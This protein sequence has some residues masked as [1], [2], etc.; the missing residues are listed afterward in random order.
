MQNWKLAPSWAKKEYNEF[1]TDTWLLKRIQYHIND[2]MLWFIVH[3]NFIGRR[4]RVHHHRLPQ[5]A[6]PQPGHRPRAPPAH[7]D[8][9][10]LQTG[11]RQLTKLQFSIL[12]GAVQNKINQFKILLFVIASISIVEQS[13]NLSHP[14]L[15]LIL[16]KAANNS[17]AAFCFRSGTKWWGST[18]TRSTGR[19]PSSGWSCGTSAPP[20][21]TFST[22]SRGRSAAS[23][24]AWPSLFPLVSECAD[25]TLRACCVCA[26]C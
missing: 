8:Q 13:C 23:S 12:K 20:T 4:L 22:R 9:P 1:L 5:R 15:S 10:G 18:T 11:G 26:Q 21:R 25:Y 6:V 24:S 14:P 2:L 16:C 7:L 17:K 3:V 19:W